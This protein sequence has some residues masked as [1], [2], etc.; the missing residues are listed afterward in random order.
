MPN[1]RP[2]RPRTGNLPGVDSG[3]PFEITIFSFGFKHGDAEGADL[4]IDV[5]DLPNPFWVEELRPMSGRDAPIRAWML[6]KEEVR[7]KID[8]VAG[9]VLQTKKD[10]L[11]RGDKEL[12]VA[13]G[14]TGGRHRSVVI[15]E[16]VAQRLTAA[17][18]EVRVE[19]RD[20]GRPASLMPD[21]QRS[22]DA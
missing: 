4:C 21:Y 16:E 22:Q 11:A 20:V 7:E 1:L 6:D 2:A 8:H 15:V 5:R 13:I 12:R 10:A 14:C 9:V 3:K 18:D 19:H 17:G